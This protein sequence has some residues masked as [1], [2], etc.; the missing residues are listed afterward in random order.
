MSKFN[1]AIAL[2]V[3]ASVALFALPGKDD[4]TNVVQKAANDRCAA[5]AAAGLE[6]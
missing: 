6:C 2:A 3:L 1:Y 4:A 5:F